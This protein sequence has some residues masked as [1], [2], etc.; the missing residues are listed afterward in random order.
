MKTEMELTELKEVLKFRCH[1]RY[2]SVTQTTKFDKLWVS[3]CVCEC[4]CGF[5]F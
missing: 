5:H 3:E 2:K 1:E 4:L